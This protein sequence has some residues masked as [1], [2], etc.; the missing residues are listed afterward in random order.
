[1]SLH[2]QSLTCIRQDRLIF[3]SV[4][5]SLSS[6]EILWVKGRNG[7]GKSS[8]LRILAG[9]LKPASGIVS[10]DGTDVEQEPE[11]YQQNLRYVGHQDALKTAYTARENLNFWSQYTGTNNVAAALEAFQLQTIA[12]HPVRILSAGQKKRSNLARLIAC[13]APLWI[14]D[15]P[16]SSLDT[17]Y[18]DLFKN[19]LETHVKAGGMAL[20]AT[21][22]D[23][24]LQSA[25]HLDLN[26]IW[27]VAG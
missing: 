2:V 19:L 8:L 12:D 26:D 20:L 23:L 15:E 22:P 9:L 16:V 18:I 5:L 24:G 6:G 11:Q 3:K 1:M 21:H 17:D 14:L 27:Q 25:R 10:W 4:E 13:P 7:A